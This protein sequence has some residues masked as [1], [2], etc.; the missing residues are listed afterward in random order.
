MDNEVKRLYDEWKARYLKKNPYV[1][2]QYFVHYNLNGESDDEYPNA[3]TTSEANGY[4]ML[5]TAYMAG[6]DAN[7]KTYFDGL[8]RFYKAHP[9]EINP[10]LMAWQQI[11]NGSAI[12]NN[13]EAGSDAATDGDMDMAYALLLADKQ[14]GSSSGINYRAEAVN[15]IN[16]IMQSEVNQKSWHLKLG[17]WASDSDSKWGK[18]T[19][20]SDFMLNHLRAFKAATGDSRW[21]NVLNQTYT[22]IQQLFS[23]YSSSTGLMPDFATK[24]SSGYKPA[25][26]T[27]LET[28]NDGN[29]YYNSCRTP[30]RIATD[31]ILTGDTRAKAQLT[32]LNSWIKSSTGSKPANIRA[33]YKLNGSPLVSYYDLPFSTPFAVSAMIDSSNQAW[34]NSLWSNTTSKST[35]G[36]TYFGNSIRLLSL[37]V[38]S[39]NWWT[40]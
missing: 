21:D 17:D 14:W 2:N 32:K 39:G 22:I 26:G 27:Y 38:V 15:L 4:G 40:P 16:A 29:Y 10:K 36:D 24:E 34:L 5:I 28:P 33:G 13:T 35:N 19:R 30:W 11:D 8:Y 1:S 20:P 3:V 23:G 12:V 7:A 18:G 25:V 37:I 9:S 6:H 31:Y